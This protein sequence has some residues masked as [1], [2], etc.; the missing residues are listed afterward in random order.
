[1]VN[2][3]KKHI[4]GILNTST[5]MAQKGFLGT[6]F[7]I[8]SLSEQGVIDLYLPLSLSLALNR[9]LIPF[10]LLSLSVRHTL[11]QNVNAN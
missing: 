1:M 2:D 7:Y 11:D 5:N 6:F 9:P 3:F 4:F 8:S 10:L